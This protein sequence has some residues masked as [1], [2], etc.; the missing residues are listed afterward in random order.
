MASHGDPAMAQLGRQRQIEPRLL[1]SQVHRAMSVGPG[2]SSR[3]D[4]RTSQPVESTLNRF[5]SCL[6]SYLAGQLGQATGESTKPVDQVSRPGQ[7]SDSGGLGGAPEVPRGCPGRVPRGSQS[8]SGGQ[9]AAKGAPEVAKRRP[10]DGQE[11]AKSGQRASRAPPRG[12]QERPR[13]AQERPRGAQ[14]RPRRG[15]RGVGEAPKRRPRAQEVIF[16]KSGQNTAPATQNPG[17]AGL[18]GG[19]KGQAAGRKCQSGGRLDRPGLDLGLIQARSGWLDGPRSSRLDL[20][21]IQ[22]RSGWLDGPRLLRP[23]LASSPGRGSAI[24]LWI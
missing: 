20:G 10:R 6:K 1:P 15:S 5:V 9:E 11:A 17:R 8:A 23:L 22:A 24:S 19:R 2:Q 21:S 16:A 14:E 7:E 4:A 13:G 3:V 12:G 18:S